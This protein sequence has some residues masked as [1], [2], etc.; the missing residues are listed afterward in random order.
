ML[1]ELGADAY[2]ELL[3]RH[4][5]A[6]R[7]AWTR[8]GGVEV[9]TAG[10]AFFVAFPT[11]SGALG[12]AADAQGRSRE[13]GLR[14]R[15]GV[16]TGEVTVAETGYVGFEVHRAARIAA[17][18]H[19]G[20]V[21][22]SAS[23]A[24]LVA[25]RRARRS[26]GAPLQ[27]PR[28]RRAGLP[29]RAGEHPPLKS[30]YRSNLPVPATPFLGRERELA[31]SWS[32]FGATAVR[33]VTLTGPGGTGKTRLSL[34]AAAEASDGFP[35]GV[36]WVPL[37]PL[38]DPALVVSTVAQAL[39]VKEQPGR[40]LVDVLCERLAGRRLLVL[41]DNAEHLLPELAVTVSRLSGVAGPTVLVTSRE[42]LQ[43]A[44]ERTYPVPELAG[45]DAV[46]LFMARAADAGVLRSARPRSRSS[47]LGSSSCRWRWSSRRR[48][49]SSSRPSSSSSGSSQRLDLLKGGRDADP[50]QRTLRATIEWSYELLDERRATAL[51]RAQRVRRR[52]HVRRGRAGRGCR[53]G[54]AA[55][56]ARQEPPSPP[57]YGSTGRA[58]GCSRPF[59]STHERCSTPRATKARPWIGTDAGA[60]PSRRPS[61]R[62]CTPTR[63]ATSSTWSRRSTPISAL[64]SSGPWHRRRAAS[65]SAS[66]LRSGRSGSRAATG[67]KAVG[68]STP[69]C[70]RT[71]TRTPTC[72]WMRSS[73]APSSR[74]GSGTSRRQVD[75][76]TSCSSSPV[77]RAALAG[78]PMR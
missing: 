52:L 36:F 21:V 61:R 25:A 53:S 19:G 70:L 5:E 7:A 56:L 47:A 50:R 8:H 78:R 27:G 29:A 33:L 68:S 11:A 4:H 63:R 44:G 32:C 40:A 17:A 46:E 62:S 34:Q 22:V 74:S 30:L 24:A 31:R 45:A 54:H 60:S 16:H 42:R 57:R 69:P 41:L 75:G 39:D 13:L 20:Q 65:R 76:P 15:M 2:G 58:T 73:G 48:A 64:R 26:G 23:T 77:G 1:E 59:A 38:D 12:A 49:R 35:D 14:V 9:D 67:A 18:A 6:C 72:A 43:L 3:S 55:V 51:S 66:P 71:M 28:G 10:D 37:A